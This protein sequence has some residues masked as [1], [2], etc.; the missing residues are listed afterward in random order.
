M[1]GPREVVLFYKYVHLPDPLAVA[2]EQEAKCAELGVSGRMRVAREGLNGSLCG[3]SSVL[4]GYVKWMQGQV[5]FS[6]IQY[7]YSAEG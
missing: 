7:K 5:A 4:Q 2:S 6:D 1:V 3:E